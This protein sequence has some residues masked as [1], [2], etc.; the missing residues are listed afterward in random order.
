M[1]HQSLQGSAD[2]SRVLPVR[3]SK[4][5]KDFNIGPGMRFP[6]S[7]SYRCGF[8][9]QACR[10]ALVTAFTSGA[11]VGFMGYTVQVQMSNKDRP[12]V[13]MTSP[14][15]FENDD[16]APVSLYIKAVQDSGLD[17]RCL[18]YAERAFVSAN[19]ARVYT[20]KIHGAVRGVW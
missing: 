10:D 1:V 16:E 13:L 15:V 9:S 3:T 5:Q 4:K 14:A 2:R 7:V 12:G 8:S 19:G 18:L 20:G 17:E 11:F 6:E